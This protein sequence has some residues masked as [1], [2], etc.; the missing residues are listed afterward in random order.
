MINRNY[1]T[2]WS[3]HSV[4]YSPNV[5][6]HC[7]MFTDGS[8]C[9]IVSKKRRPSHSNADIIISDCSSN[10]EHCFDKRLCFS[11]SELVSD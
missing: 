8:N 6:R 2:K 4:V 9:D 1:G 7:R 11:L 3:V 10:M 5:Y